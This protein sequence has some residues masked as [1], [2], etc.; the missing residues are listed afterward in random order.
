MI[1]GCAYSIVTDYENCVSKELIFEFKENLK[2]YSIDD[3]KGKHKYSSMNLPQGEH[4][5]YICSEEEDQC[6]KEYSG[7]YYY[8][9][10]RLIKINSKLFH[11]TGRYKKNEP[12]IILGMFAPST[13]ALQIEINGENIWLSDY[14]LDIN[15]LTQSSLKSIKQ[16]NENRKLQT[17]WNDYMTEFQCPNKDVRENSWKLIWRN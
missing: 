17:D 6:L 13:S 7:R 11:L 16:L 10:W 9:G 12:N 4:H 8:Q 1:H 15:N 14:E 5:L 3:S 2:L